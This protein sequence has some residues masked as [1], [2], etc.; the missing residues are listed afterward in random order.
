SLPPRSRA[1]RTRRASP[2][3]VAASPRRTS[4][5]HMPT[6]RRRAAA[7]CTGPAPRIS[8]SRVGAWARASDLTLSDPAFRSNVPAAGRK[9]GRV[10][11]GGNLHLPKGP[12][13]APGA[14]IQEGP[15]DRRST[16][17][18]RIALI[19]LALA[20]ASPPALARHYRHWHGWYGGNYNY[21]GPHYAVSD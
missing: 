15:I 11:F 18:P 13:C 8:S 12:D 7:G 21:G 2:G 3:T 17:T 19:L 9:A 20:T 5:C 10:S 16:M 4:A 1:A 6:R 14:S